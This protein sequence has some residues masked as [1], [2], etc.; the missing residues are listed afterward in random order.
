MTPTTTGN[1]N[2]I[3]NIYA[4]YDNLITEGETDKNTEPLIFQSTN[5]NLKICMKQQNMIKI[6]QC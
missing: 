2:I 1:E 4:L 3:K 6:K 5:L